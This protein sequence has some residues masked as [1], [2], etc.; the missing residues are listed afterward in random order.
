MDRMDIALGLYGGK[1]DREC[2]T[3][4]PRTKA[5]G[6]IFFYSSFNTLFLD[7]KISVSESGT[8]FCFI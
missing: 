5:P 2:R 4:A 3:K 7:K 1:P 8:P 6:H